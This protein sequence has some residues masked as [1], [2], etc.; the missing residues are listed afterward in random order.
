MD[1]AKLLDTL[2]K[3]GYVKRDEALKA[4]K[5]KEKDEDIISALY[6]MGFFKRY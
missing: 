6:R 3:L 1:E 2:V 5:E 4:Q